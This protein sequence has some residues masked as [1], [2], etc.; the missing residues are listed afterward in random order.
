MIKKYYN[1]YNNFVFDFIQKE[2]IY[3]NLTKNIKMNKNSKYISKLKKKKAKLKKK[4]LKSRIT[5]FF[6]IKIKFNLQ[7]WSI[8]LLYL[9]NI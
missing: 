8:A 3:T 5:L 2:E 4:Y 1:N 6:Q 7:K 9:N